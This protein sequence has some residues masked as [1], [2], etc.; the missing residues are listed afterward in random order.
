MERYA[1]LERHG[2]EGYIPAHGTYKQEKEGFIYDEKEDVWICSQGKK[3]TF[4]RFYMERGNLVKRYYT[5]RKDCKDCP[6]KIACIGKQHEK[7]ISK[8]AYQAEYERMIARVESSKGQYLKKRR[9]A[10]V[11]PV[12]GTLINFMGMRKVNTRGLALAHKNFVLAAA[13]YNLKKYLNFTK[14]R[15]L[16][17]VNA[18]EGQISAIFN[19]P[20]FC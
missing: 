10:T 18:L 3:A 20:S 7:K 1:I 8:T 12:L 6:I 4:R 17:Q 2:I 9:Q 11:E 16:A 19:M 15:V 14:K 5:K 13:S